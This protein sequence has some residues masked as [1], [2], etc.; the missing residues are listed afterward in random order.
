M[1][2]SDVTIHAR[3]PARLR[4][5]LEKEAARRMTTQSTIIREALIQA[6]GLGLD[7]GGERAQELAP[8]Q[9]TGGER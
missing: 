8:R 2:L 1:P 9:I 4:E 5:A 3:A 6:L 7:G